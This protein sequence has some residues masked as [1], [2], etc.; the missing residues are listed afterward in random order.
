MPQEQA[1][2]LETLGYR[3]DQLRRLAQAA[4]ESAR[5][6]QERARHFPD[7]RCGAPAPRTPGGQCAHRPEPDIGPSPWAGSVVD[8]HAAGARKK[9]TRPA[10]RTAMPSAAPA[11]G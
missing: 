5:R 8:Q 3:A 2:G 1:T 9:G 7:S 11:A 6:H 4:T 10:S